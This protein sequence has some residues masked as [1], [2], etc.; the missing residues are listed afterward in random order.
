VPASSLIDG[1]FNRAQITAILII[2]RSSSSSSGG[3]GGAASW[4]DYTP[5][6]D[7]SDLLYREGA[8]SSRRE[9]VIEMKIL[10]DRRRITICRQRG[11]GGG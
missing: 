4:S 7:A 3:G 2:T 9:Q 10:S 8:G 11:C 1:S 5:V 6:K